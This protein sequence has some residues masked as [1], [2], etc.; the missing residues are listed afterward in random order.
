LLPAIGA[1]STAEGL[2]VLPTVPPLP[3]WPLLSEP[4]QYATPSAVS[5]QL[6][7]EPEA[8]LTKSNRQASF[9]SSQPALHG[10]PE[11]TLHEPPLQVSLPLQN[12]VSSQGAVLLGWVQPP[13]PSQ[14]S[15]VQPLLSELHGLPRGELQL[16]LVSPQLLAHSGPAMHGSPEWTLHEPSLQVSTPLQKSLSSQGAAE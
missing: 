12:S 5:P 10:S 6:W 16:W 11:W 14:T 1:V 9:F 15:S 3:S 7:N 8:I 4:Q 13:A 2:C